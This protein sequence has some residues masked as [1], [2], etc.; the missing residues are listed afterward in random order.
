MRFDAVVYREG[1]WE[2]ICPIERRLKVLSIF[3]FDIVNEMLRY[4]SVST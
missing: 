3:N 1:L 2:Q 4:L